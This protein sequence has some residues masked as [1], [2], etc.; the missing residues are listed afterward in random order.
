MIKKIDSA[1]LSPRR[2]F[3][4]RRS[5]RLLTGLIA[6]AILF[7]IALPIGTRLYLQKWL[8]ENGADKAT[9]EKVRF[10]PFTGVAALQ[11][12]DTGGCPEKII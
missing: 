5:V 12:V 6:C 4:K 11:G 2:S 1:I 10:N 8:V 3:W 9:I 7:L